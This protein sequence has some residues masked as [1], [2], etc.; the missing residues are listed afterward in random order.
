MQKKGRVIIMKILQVSKLTKTYRQGNET[1]YAVKDAAISISEGQFIVITGTSDSGKSTLLNL[2]AG[3]LKPTGGTI[4]FCGQ[5]VAALSY[6]VLA[7]YRRE[8]IGMVFQ[9]FDLL[10]MMTVRENILLPSIL[11][12]RTPDEQ[13]FD[14]LVEILGIGDRLEHFP[15]E[16]SGGQAQRT[17]IARSLINTPKLLFAD[18]PTGN[19]DAATAHEILGLLLKVNRSGVAMMLVTHD[20]SIRDRILKEAPDPQL[21]NMENGTLSRI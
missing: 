15:S 7:A 5:D 12:G 2:C 1:I 17:A 11:A 20:L 6:D 9:S 16:L 14:E 19:L 13:R 18:E 4:H 21:F 8:S 10:P 3:M